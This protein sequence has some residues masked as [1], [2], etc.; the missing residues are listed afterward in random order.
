MCFSRQAAWDAWTSGLTACSCSTVII[1][2]HHLALSGVFCLS[3][4]LLSHTYRGFIQALGSPRIWWLICG[5]TWYPSETLIRVF[6]WGHRRWSGQFGASRNRDSSVDYRSASKSISSILFSAFGAYSFPPET[7]HSAFHLLAWLM[8]LRSISRVVLGN[9]EHPE[10]LSDVTRRILTG[11]LMDSI[12]PD[13]Y[14]GTR[15]AEL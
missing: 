12:I 7:L 6:Q 2:Q 10:L 13:T 4:E 8:C 14:D 5:V 3:A 1:S 11:F 15:P 9:R